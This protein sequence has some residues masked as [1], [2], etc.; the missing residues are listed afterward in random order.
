MITDWKTPL[1]PNSIPE[2]TALLSALVLTLA[3]FLCDLLTPDNI[4]LRMLYIF[5]LV[6]NGTHVVQARTRHAVTALVGAAAVYSVLALPHPLYARLAQLGITL[7]SL[8]LTLMLIRLSRERYLELEHTAIRDPLT[9]LY[10]RREFQRALAS[11]LARLKRYGGNCSLAMIDVDG[12]KRVNDTQGHAAGDAVLRLVAQILTTHTRKTD[13]VARYGGDEFVVL[14]PNTHRQSCEKVCSYLAYI[15]AS[16]LQNAELGLS[17]SIG[18][19][20]FDT[21][22][23]SEAAAI[24][25]ADEAMYEAKARGKGCSVVW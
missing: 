10:N 20:A 6:I 4:S 18:G 19:V 1:R 11:E 5:P 7:A 22:P 14:M 9:G 21:P 17:A 12:F 16:A 13:T 25:Q 8:L 2:P 3:I 15:I 24:R 23:G